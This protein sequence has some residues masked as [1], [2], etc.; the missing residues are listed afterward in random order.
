MM[1]YETRENLMFGGVIC[2]IMAVGAVGGGIGAL[3]G[4]SY[5]HECSFEGH[6]CQPSA[7]LNAPENISVTEL[8]LLAELDK[9]DSDV[10]KDASIRMLNDIRL[11]G[12][13]VA[14]IGFARVKDQLKAVRDEKWAQE[15]FMLQTRVDFQKAMAMATRA[16]TENDLA[17]QKWAQLDLDWAKLEKGKMEEALKNMRSMKILAMAIKEQHLELQ[18]AMKELEEL[19]VEDAQVGYDY[20]AQVDYDYGSGGGGKDG[21]KTR[22]ELREREAAYFSQQDWKAEWERNAAR[23]RQLMN[24][25]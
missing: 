8:A 7:L 10:D 24:A 4:A 17:S 22:S 15:K 18:N 11:E 1:S 9:P 14:R 12:K 19:D 2:A 20:G 5:A 21:A 6:T 3:T 23:V 13:V 25:K 16:D